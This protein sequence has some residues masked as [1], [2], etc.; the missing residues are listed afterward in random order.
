MLKISSKWSIILSIGLCAGFMA[1]CV[2]GLFLMP[3][4]V[5]MLIRIPD[6]IG[7]RGEITQGSKVFIHILAYL[8]LVGGMV[9]DGLLVALLMRVRN[10]KVFTFQSVAIIRAVSWCCFFV[11]LV[12]GIIGIYFKLSFIVAFGVLLLGL[13]LRVMKNVLEE[14]TEIKTENDLT[15]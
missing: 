2:V 1:A 4:L 3:S 11:C 12:F 7:F 6:N 5:E 15:V 9:A 14:A 10:G 13:C 8:A